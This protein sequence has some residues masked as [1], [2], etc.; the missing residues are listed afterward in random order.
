M[1]EAA[2]VSALLRDVLRGIGDGDSAFD[3]LANQERALRQR[4]RNFST[5]GRMSRDELYQRRS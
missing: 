4:V 3:R 5:A 1:Y 2:S